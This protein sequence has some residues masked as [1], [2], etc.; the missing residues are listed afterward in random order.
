VVRE[1]KGVVWVSHRCKRC[2]DLKENAKERSWMESHYLVL[3]TSEDTM[4]QKK[5]EETRAMSGMEKAS[6]EVSR[7]PRGD[8]QIDVSNKNRGTHRLRVRAN[9]LRASMMWRAQWRDLFR[10][11]RKHDLARLVCRLTALRKLETEE[12]SSLVLSRANPMEHCKPLEATK[13]CKDDVLM[14]LSEDPYENVV[15]SARHR[16][17][18]EEQKTVLP[19]V[20]IVKEE[21]EEEEERNIM[22]QSWNNI[23]DMLDKLRFQEI[24]DSETV[25]ETDLNVF[26]RRLRM[27][28]SLQEAGTRL[29]S[30]IDEKYPDLVTAVLLLAL[31]R[32]DVARASSQIPSTNPIVRPHDAGDILEEARRPARAQALRTFQKGL[33]K[34]EMSNELDR[35]LNNLL[36]SVEERKV[37]PLRNTLESSARQSVYRRLRSSLTTTTMNIPGVSTHDAVLV[38]K[39]RRR[40]GENPTASRLAETFVLGDCVWLKRGGAKEC[41]RI[42][43]ES[44]RERFG[45]QSV[46]YVVFFSLLPPTPVYTHQLPFTQQIR[47]TTKH[48]SSQVSPTITKTTQVFYVNNKK[49]TSKKNDYDA[50]TYYSVHKTTHDKTTKS[51][52]QS[53]TRDTISSRYCDI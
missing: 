36:G 19:P 5:H 16:R 33:D 40:G 7:N 39:R 29:A 14:R 1:S 6:I 28:D 10:S 4:Y 48:I 46:A 45:T 52:T 17:K 47:S 37:V 43:T 53:T 27:L 41:V 35:N 8:W 32:A 50:T 49:T 13:W 24:P 12:F 51:S 18:D 42:L 15:V 3:H 31:P 38:T 25:I 26:E 2:R 44:I 9:Q 30:R 23:L 34:K 21:E 20:A 22:I 11:D